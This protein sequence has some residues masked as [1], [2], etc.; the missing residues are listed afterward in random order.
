[1]CLLR[2]TLQFLLIGYGSVSG[3]GT[4]NLDQWAGLVGSG[5]YQVYYYHLNWIGSDTR[6]HQSY[7]WRIFCKGGTMDGRMVIWMGM[8]GYRQ[9]WKLRWRWRLRAIVCLLCHSIC[10]FHC[11]SSFTAPGT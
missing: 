2:Y 5:Y 1:M 8:T 9:I 4:W 11:H 3:T 6:D 7:L 10:L